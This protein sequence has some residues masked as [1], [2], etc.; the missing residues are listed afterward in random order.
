MNLNEMIA[1]IDGGRAVDVVRALNALVGCPTGGW[2]ETRQAMLAI[3]DEVPRGA[4]FTARALVD[5]AL[6]VDS[7]GRYQWRAEVSL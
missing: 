1:M 3:S 6:C 4:N 5:A 7:A 2:P